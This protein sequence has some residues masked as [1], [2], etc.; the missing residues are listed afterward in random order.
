MQNGTC[1]EK[2]R[3]CRELVS[4]LLFSVTITTRYQTVS[5]GAF[6]SIA[7]SR[8]RTLKTSLFFHSFSDPRE[9]RTVCFPTR[10]KESTA[11]ETETETSIRPLR[12][13]TG[14][15]NDD[16]NGLHGVSCCRLKGSLS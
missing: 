11:T 4:A 5:G 15:Q 10:E 14:S 7:L 1:A 16:K 12:E 8:P 9:V 3:I 2:S 6:L 13:A